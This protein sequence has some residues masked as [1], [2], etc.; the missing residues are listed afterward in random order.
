MDP[1]VTSARLPIV[2]IVRPPKVDMA[3]WIAPIERAARTPRGRLGGRLAAGALLLA[4]LGVFA[5]V[6][7]HGAVA[8]LAADPHH[9]TLSVHRQRAIAAATRFEQPRGVAA[10]GAEAAPSNVPGEIAETGVS[11]RPVVQVVPVTGRR[12]SPRGGLREGV[13]HRPKHGGAKLGK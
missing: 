2:R 7:A 13:A 6:N 4:A 11:A 9:A 5:S 8:E 3:E 10:G 12:E 1:A